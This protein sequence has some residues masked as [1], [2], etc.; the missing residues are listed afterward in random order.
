M[1]SKRLTWLVTGTS[2]V[3]PSSPLAHIS[4]LDRSGIGRELVLNILARGDKVIATARGR[5]FSKL[6][7]LRE[8]GGYIC[9]LDV[10]SGQD[11]LNAFAKQIIGEH[12]HIDVLVNNA[13]ALTVSYQQICADDDH[14]I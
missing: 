3:L 9:E 11:H 6:T 1:G 13:G 2:Y 8:K 12:G 10:V 14:Y 4:F 5:S 7:D